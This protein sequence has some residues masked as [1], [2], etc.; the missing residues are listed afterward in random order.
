MMISQLQ[1][2]LKS[3]HRAAADESTAI[4]AEYSALLR[5]YIVRAFERADRGE[6]WRSNTTASFR[7]RSLQAAV[8]DELLRAGLERG[9]V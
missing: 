9:L 3:Q 8:K 7:M 5:T 4:E 1:L 6:L 2:V